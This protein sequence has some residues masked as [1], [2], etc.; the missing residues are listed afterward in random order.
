[1]G[2]GTSPSFI[3]SKPGGG[4]VEFNNFGTLKLSELPVPYFA[5]KRCAYDLRIFLDF[6]RKN[7]YCLIV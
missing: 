4:G 6:V 2:Y 3:M 1:M 5:Y 7:L